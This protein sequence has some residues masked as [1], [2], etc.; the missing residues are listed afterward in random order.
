[1]KQISSALKPVCSTIV[2]L[3]LIFSRREAKAQ[4]FQR[5]FTVNGRVINIKDLNR[6]IKAILDSASCP[7]L[8]FAVIDHDKVVFYNTYGYKEMSRTNSGRLKGNGKVNKNTIF[9]A[10]SCSKNFFALAVNRLLDQGVLDL[11][12]PLYKYLEYPKLAYDDRYKLITARMVLSHTSG[13]ENW[14]W[15]NDRTQL[16]FI[17]NPGEKFWY[18]G[19][20]YMYLAKVIEKLTNKS[21]EQYMNELVIEPLH[22]KRTFLYFSKDGKSPGNYCLGHTTF[23]DPVRHTK[24]QAPHMASYIHTTAK[25]YATLLAAFFNGQYLPRKQIEE[26]VGTDLVHHYH[27]PEPIPYNHWGLGFAVGYENQDTVVYQAGNNGDFKGYGWYSVTKKIGYTMFAN[28]EFGDQLL[29][30]LDSLTTGEHTIFL[31]EHN[32][33][34]KERGIQYPSLKFKL[35]H[36]YN[37]EGYPDALTYFRTIASNKDYAISEDDF[38]ECVDLFMGKEPEFAGYIAAE[39]ENRYPSSQEAIFLHG[40]VMVQKEDFEGAVNDFQ[41][42]LKADTTRQGEINDLISR[43]SRKKQ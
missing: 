25:D 29:E 21:P 22:L 31:P 43:Y 27:Y 26:V 6:K 18:S 3:L 34:G 14:K 23:L 17:A 33:F 13:L 19:E 32:I 37:K 8:S 10:C 30:V 16:E 7:G 39:Y 24:N 15:D 38:E 40:K 11:D 2:I 41:R 35:L 4:L 5:T 12:V 28:G 36:V 42:A 20:G 1:M 9:E